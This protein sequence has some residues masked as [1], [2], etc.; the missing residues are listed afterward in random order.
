M[1]PIVVVGDT[2]RIAGFAL[3]GAT[4]VAADNEDD[5][6]AAW[7][8]LPDDVALVVLTPEAAAV[9]ADRLKMRPMVLT[10]VIPP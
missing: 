4:T 5:V 10:A 9:L 8:G 6:H 1:P 2:T 7:S 3:A